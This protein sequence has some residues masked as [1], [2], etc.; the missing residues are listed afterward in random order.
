MYFHWATFWGL[1][2]PI[3]FVSFLNFD[4]MI[5]LTDY[6]GEACHSVLDSMVQ[7]TELRLSSLVAGIIC[8]E[9]ILLDEILCL[10]RRKHSVFNLKP[11]HLSDSTRIC[12]FLVSLV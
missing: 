2:G 10:E 7:G 9:P 8:T 12:F 6:W 3:S 5:L 4:W 11:K 1:P